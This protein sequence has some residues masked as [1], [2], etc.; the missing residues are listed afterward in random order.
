[1]QAV[2]EKKLSVDMRINALN[3][4]CALYLRSARVGPAVS[5]SVVLSISSSRNSNA[6]ADVVAQFTS[7]LNE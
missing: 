1:M 7:L 2:P 3:F 4:L 6:S 5:S